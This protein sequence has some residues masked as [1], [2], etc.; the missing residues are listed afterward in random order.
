MLGAMGKVALYSTLLVLGLLLSQ[1]YPGLVPNQAETLALVIKLATFVCLAF[2]MIHVG[3]EF[4]I[5]KSRLGSYGWDY[6]VAMTAAAFPW[7]FVAAY[8]VFAMKDSSVWGDWTAWKEALLIGRFAAP[9]SAGVL[10]SM[11]AAA[12]LAATWLFKKARVLAIF[13]D[14]DT[15][16]LMIPLKMMIIGPKPQLG[17]VVV[18]MALLLWIGWKYL[19]AIDIPITWPWVIGYS[20]VLVAL[21]EAFYIVTEWLQP[22]G[23]IHFEVLLPAFILGCVIRSHP[24]G[25]DDHSNGAPASNPHY[26]RSAIFVSGFISAAFMILVGLSMPAFAQL[27]GKGGEASVSWWTIAAHVLIVT[28]LSNLGK[29]FPAFCYRDEATF[30]E[31]LAVAIGMWPRG[32]VGAGV[33]VVALSYGMQGPFVLVA[34]LS[35]ALNLVLTGVFIVI[36]KRLIAPQT[37]S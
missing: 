24:T 12:G 27:L 21:C 20:V 13:D 22:G 10:F 30:R 17:V 16:L 19:H 32:E 4:E 28:V 37:S 25:G 15:V 6:V 36:V 31:R 26:S 33:L 3:H 34:M 7:I 11:L 2:I 35:L 8:F 14:I 5:D 29:M 23:G 18:V 1:V 9:T